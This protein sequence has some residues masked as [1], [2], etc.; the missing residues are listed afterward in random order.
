MSR[1]IKEPND[2]TNKNVQSLLKSLRDQTLAKENQ[3]LFNCLYTF[4]LIVMLFKCEV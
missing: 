2:H 1:L 3:L 4:R